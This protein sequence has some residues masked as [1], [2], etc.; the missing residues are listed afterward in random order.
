MFSGRERI[1]SSSR[2]VQGEFE[3]PSVISDEYQVPSSGVKSLGSWVDHSP[4]Y[5]I[6]YLLELWLQ[7]PARLRHSAETLLSKGIINEFTNKRIIWSR[8]LLVNPTVPQLVKHLPTIYGPQSFIPAPTTARTLNLSQTTFQYI[9]PI[10][11]LILIRYDIF[12]NCNCVDTR[13]HT[14]NIQG[15]TGGTDQTSGECSLC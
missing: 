11:T 12:V 15:V 14:N 13:W 6:E 5:N 9:S 3:V 8:V 4:S 10:S 2:H 7:C 1:A